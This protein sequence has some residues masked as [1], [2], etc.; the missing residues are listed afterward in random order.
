MVK[1]KEYTFLATVVGGGKITIPL[2]VRKLLKIDDDMQIE[3]TVR[4]IE[5]D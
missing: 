3:A 1:Q 5:K 4:L 2:E